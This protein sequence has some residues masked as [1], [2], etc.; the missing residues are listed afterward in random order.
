MHLLHSTIVFTLLAASAVNLHAEQEQDAVHHWSAN[1]GLTSDYLF[2]GMSRSAEDPAVQGGL[3]YSYRPIGFYAGVW[4][5]SI[6]F[7]SQSSDDASTEIDIYAG[8]GGSFANDVDWKLGGV[9]QYFP[10]QNADHPAG[11]FDFFELQGALSYEFKHA[12][13]TP[14]ISTE[15]AYSPDYFGEDGDSIYLAGSFRVSLPRSLSF[16]SKLGYLDV[17]GGQTISEGYDYA[18]Y[19]IGLERALGP[20]TLDLSWNDAQDDCERVASDDYCDAA[21]FN[22]STAW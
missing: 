10:G 11:D 13:I 18:H 3:D 4:A 7:D 17:A 5:S 20:I 19:K 14:I 9:Y 2:R 12:L 22:V 21:V 1:V 16:Y 6:E 15:F 8:F